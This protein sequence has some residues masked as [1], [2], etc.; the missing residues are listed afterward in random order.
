[1]YFETLRTRLIAGIQARVRNGEMTER[2]LAR[3]T[4]LSQPHIHNL[5]KGTRALSPPVADRILQRLEISVLDLLLPAE[6]DSRR[7]ELD[8]AGA[9]SNREPVPRGRAGPR[10]TAF[11]NKTFSPSI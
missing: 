6:L 10:K 9:Y 7:T 5:L 4:G 11:R 2:G 1:M 3:L 8:G